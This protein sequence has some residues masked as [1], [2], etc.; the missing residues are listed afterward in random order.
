MKRMVGV[1]G[2]CGTDWCEILMGG[3]ASKCEG[4]IGDVAGG[5]KLGAH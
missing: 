5:G 1:G 3:N 4:V 2:G